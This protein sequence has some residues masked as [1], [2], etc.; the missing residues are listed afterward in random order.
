MSVLY[1]LLEYFIFFTHWGLY[2]TYTLRCLWLL[3][4]ASEGEKKK[5]LWT[6]QQEKHTITLSVGLLQQAERIAKKIKKK[7]EYRIRIMNNKTLCMY[8]YPII[9][10]PNNSN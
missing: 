10:N 8:M 3:S 9:V 6:D 5:N 7:I 4:I 1:L 2:Q